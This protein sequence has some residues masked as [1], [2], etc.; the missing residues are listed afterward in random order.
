MNDQTL[1]E[2]AEK[3][4]EARL[5]DGAEEEEKEP[6]QTTYYQDGEILAE[7]IYD[8]A[9]NPCQQ[10]CVFNKLSQSISTHK[11]LFKDGE[12]Y[13]PVGNKDVFEKKIVLFPTSVSEYGDDRSLNLRIT[14]FVKKYLDIEESLLFLIPYF[15]KMSWVYDRGRIVCYLAGRGDFGSGKTRFSDVI[16]SICYKPIFLAGATSDAY[17]FRCIELF[18]GTLVINELERINT[19]IYSQIVNILNN[20]YEKGHPI[21][22]VEGDR[23]RVLRAFDV[24]SPKIITSRGQFKDLALESRI[25][26]VGLAETRRDDI[27]D[28]LPPEFEM[29]ALDIRNNLLLYRFRNLGKTMDIP[30]GEL[31]G[32]SRRTRQTFRP[33]MLCAN[34]NQEISEIAACARNYQ[35]EI[36]QDRQS[37]LEGVAV[38]IL[39]D[40]HSSGQRLS[41]GEWAE[42]INQEIKNPKELM[43]PRRLGSIVRK[44]FKLTTEQ[45]TGGLY[46]VMYDEE[47]LNYLFYR[48]GIGSQTSQSSQSISSDSTVDLVD[49]VDSSRDSERVGGLTDCGVCGSKDF[50]QRHDGEII[51]AVCHPPVDPLPG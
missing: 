3:E 6:I 13:I 32:L 45:S 38:K 26:N 43:T 9:K 44:S 7:E 46:Y 4:I 49:L 14:S 40:T 51:C 35:S 28:E 20:G 10:F 23:K 33:L 2:K 31:G 47:R 34:T 27:P 11:T 19:D 17:L 12:L 18:K 37:S 8:E 24:F 30:V 16:G 29:E 21:G 41:I 39:F 1:I 5:D 25:I 42:R 36:L 22:R 15:V 50:W 48:Y